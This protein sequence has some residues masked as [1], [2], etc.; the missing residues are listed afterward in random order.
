MSVPPSQ[1]YV[2]H[3]SGEQGPLSTQELWRLVQQGQLSPESLVRGAEQTR[4]QTVRE[5]L[6]S[7][8]Y[9]VPQADNPYAAPMATVVQGGTTLSGDVAPEVLQ[10][11]AQTR[12][13]VMFLAI[14]GFIA[15][16]LMGI[17]VVVGLAAAAFPPVVSS[18]GGVVEGIL[19]AGVYYV[20]VLLYGFLSWYLF[21]YARGIGRLLASPTVPHLVVALQ[22]QR[23]FWRLV[24]IV[25]LVVVVVYAS[26]C[27]FGVGVGVIGSL[28]R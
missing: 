18:S 14:L 19:V 4:W 22:A 8:G 11:L 24:G 17:G 1:W 2:Q 27:V 28:T 10:P 26:L 23:S 13:W 3:S 5:V 20:G 25:T 9:A 12:P 21:S 6:A 15:T 7:E 16:G